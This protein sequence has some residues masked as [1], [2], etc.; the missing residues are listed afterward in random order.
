M[1]EWLVMERDFP[2]DTIEWECETEEQAEEIIEFCPE[3]KFYIEKAGASY[4]TA[5]RMKGLSSVL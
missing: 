1:I 2:N 5:Q 4:F 3:R